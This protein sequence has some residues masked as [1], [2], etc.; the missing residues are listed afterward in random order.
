MAAKIKKGDT[1][2]VLAGKDKGSQGVVLKVQPKEGRLVVQGIN[3]VKRHVKASMADPE[4][5]IRTQEAALDVSNVAV[6][7]QA[8]ARWLQGFARWPQ[9]AGGQALRS[10]DRCL[11]SQP[12]SRG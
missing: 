11:R 8:D 7:R 6:N 1:V 12:M 9:G 3:L 5:G 2:I 10:A 4:G